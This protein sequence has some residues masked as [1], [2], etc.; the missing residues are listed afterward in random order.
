[1]GLF[2]NAQLLLEKELLSEMEGS[3][4]GKVARAGSGSGNSGF[5]R[6]MRNYSTAVPVLYSSSRPAFPTGQT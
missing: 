4:D 6:R 1:M 5:N 2:S 3:G